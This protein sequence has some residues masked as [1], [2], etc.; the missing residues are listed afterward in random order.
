MRALVVDD[1]RTVRAIL[2]R[3]LEELGFDVVEADNGRDALGH[4]DGAG[5]A[6]VVLVDWG[7]P[8]MDGIELIKAIRAVHGGRDVRI[9]MVTRET[10]LSGV[11]EALEAGADEYVMKPFTKDVI[12]EKLALV[13][14]A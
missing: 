13:G 14:L 4:L 11:M 10:R 12:R 9:V 1:S 7:M 5:A 8:E 3:I 6:D 2:R